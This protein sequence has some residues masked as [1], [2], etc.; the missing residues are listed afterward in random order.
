MKVLK[1]GGTSVA[2]ADVIKQVRE[3]LVGTKSDRLAV[4]V[5]ALGG[6]TDLLLETMNTASRQDPSYRKQLKGI[7]DRHLGV[8]R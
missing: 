7:E 4:V 1:F 6:V 8:I 3:I 5:S 2:S